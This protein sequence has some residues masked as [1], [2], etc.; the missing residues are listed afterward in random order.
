MQ[1]S[2]QDGLPF[3]KAFVENARQNGAREY[4]KMRAPIIKEQDLI[5]KTKQVSAFE[6]FLKE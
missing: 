5:M 2:F 3:L 1:V 4:Q 6:N